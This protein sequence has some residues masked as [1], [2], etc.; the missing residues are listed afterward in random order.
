MLDIQELID[1]EMIREKIYRYCRAVDRLDS[2]EL[3]GIFWDDAR[4]IGGPFPDDNTP[5]ARDF[6]KLGMKVTVEDVFAQS[7][8]SISNIIIDIDGDVA[9]SES[10][11]HCHHISHPTEAGRIALIGAENNA[12]F[13]YSGADVVEMILGLRYIDRF[14]KRARE[15][16]IAK[17]SLV[18]D[19]SQVQKWRGITHGGLYENLRLRGTRG[20]ED[21]VYSDTMQR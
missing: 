18:I 14:E 4:Y 16:R 5:P 15:W 10:Y 6:L 19:W 11:A 13:K 1:R 12:E 17:R 7:M 8:H 2:A 9:F 21:P 3:N 20:I